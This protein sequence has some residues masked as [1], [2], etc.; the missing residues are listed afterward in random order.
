VPKGIPAILA[1]SRY[2][3]CSSSRSSL[4]Q[5]QYGLR[6]T[7][8]PAGAVYCLIEVR[9]LTRCALLPQ[10]VVAPIAY[11]GQQPGTPVAA[12]KTCKV[13]DGAQ[14]CVLNHVLGLGFVA[15]Q[16]ASQVVCRVQVRYQQCH[17]TL[18]SVRLARPFSGC[19]RQVLY[20]ELF[21]SLGTILAGGCRI[22][23]AQSAFPASK[24]LHS[25]IR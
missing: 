15:H 3:S 18:G 10:T 17:V 22:A 14:V 16:P 21:S 13:A 1:I 2:D 9:V 24:F 20:H 7:G 19:R 5:Q 23:N 4:C 11:D 25:A 8:L 12:S 6:V